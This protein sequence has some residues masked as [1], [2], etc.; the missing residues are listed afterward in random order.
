MYRYSIESSL[1]DPVVDASLSDIVPDTVYTG[2]FAGNLELPS[3]ASTVSDF[4]N[5]MVITVAGGDWNLDC[6]APDGTTNCDAHDNGPAATCT[7]NQD[8]AGTACTAIALDE[9]RTIVSYAGDTKVFTV[10]TAFSATLT[11]SETFSIA[12]TGTDAAAR[13]AVS[14]THLTLPTNREV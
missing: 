9:S 5:G 10:N 3:T 2:N 11:T 7:S 13:V 12:I 14:Y 1:L 8:G 6:V 4:Y